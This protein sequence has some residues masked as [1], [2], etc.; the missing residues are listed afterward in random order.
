MVWGIAKY[1]S[2]AV[3][4]NTTQPNFCELPP[5]ELSSLQDLAGRLEQIAMQNHAEVHY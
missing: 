5:P 4:T 3:K 2:L 1:K